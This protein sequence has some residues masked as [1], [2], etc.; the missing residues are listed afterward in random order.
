MM[1][2]KIV[3]YK[4]FF[5]FKALGMALKRP[6]SVPSDH[7]ARC[8]GGKI[9][10][11]LGDVHSE[12]YSLERTPAVSRGNHSTNGTLGPDVSVTF[13]AIWS[14]ELWSK[15]WAA[16]PEFCALNTFRHDSAQ[17]HSIPWNK[18]SCI[19]TYGNRRSERPQALRK[20]ATSAPTREASWMTSHGG[21]H[22]SY[23]SKIGGQ[24]SRYQWKEQ[25][26]P[27]D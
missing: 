24:C 22:L 12:T 23:C 7:L 13:R 14:C 19:R 11:S 21:H 26:T 16:Q 5:A 9:A 2:Y 25:I 18:A 27:H 15:D 4:R 3:F 10:K 17:I 1:L 6:N 8:G 20:M